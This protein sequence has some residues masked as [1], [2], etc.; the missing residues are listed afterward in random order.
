MARASHRPR[1]G[2][3]EDYRQDY[4][5]GRVALSLSR[6]ISAGIRRDVRMGNDRRRR[7]DDPSREACH[8]HENPA[9]ETVRLVRRSL[10]DARG[11]RSPRLVRH[12]PQLADRR[13]PH[14]R[15]AVPGCRSRPG[16]RVSP[17]R[18]RST[19]AGP[20]PSACG[21]NGGPP[22][23]PTRVVD[24]RWAA[25]DSSCHRARSGGQGCR[26]GSSV[27][28]RCQPKRD[29]R[30]L[31]RPGVPAFAGCRGYRP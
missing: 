27:R 3:I 10:A 24:V 6:N 16:L 19:R 17:R 13:R 20:P 29:A 1:Q 25:I 2:P 14:L 5:V 11:R 23:P 28:L 9:A 26:C 22:P 21:P 7:R 31:R 18:R 30:S 15:D 4:V 12:R 8:P